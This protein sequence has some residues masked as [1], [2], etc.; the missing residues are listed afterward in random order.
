MKI[1]KLKDK[2]IL[3]SWATVN[4][5][6]TTIGTL[7]KTK[8]GR[9]YRGIQVGMK[10]FTTPSRGTIIWRMSF[11]HEISHV[12]LSKEM[13]TEE[14]MANSKYAFRQEVIAWRLAK[15][16]MKPKYWK[17]EQAIAALWGFTWASLVDMDKLKI[18]EWNE[19][20]KL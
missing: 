1:V 19:G 6:D 12:L 11:A 7:W 10:P 16:L 5:G 15:S 13:N 8:D 17:E 3:Y 18:I 20:I 9:Q 4:L 14:Y 2:S